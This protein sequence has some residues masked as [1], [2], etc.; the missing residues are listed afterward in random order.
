MARRRVSGNN[1][2]EYK[3]D[4]KPCIFDTNWGCDLDTSLATVLG[5]TFLS[6]NCGVGKGKNG[7]IVW[8]RCILGLINEGDEISYHVSISSPNFL[9][10]SIHP[11]LQL[12]H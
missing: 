8:D 5:Q 9:N 7:G 10:P 12:H 2:A 3:F 11:V 1:A 6:E 4:I